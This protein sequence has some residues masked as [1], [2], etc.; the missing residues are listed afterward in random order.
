MNRGKAILN[1]EPGRIEG[2]MLDVGENK[3]REHGIVVG[4]KSLDESCSLFVPRLQR[5][6]EWGGNQGLRNLAKPQLLAPGYHV[7]APLALS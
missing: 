3:G 4:G 5:S 6:D 7:V 1:F 2:A